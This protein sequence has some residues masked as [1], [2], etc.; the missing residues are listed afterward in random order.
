MKST[1]AY[2]EPGVIFI[3]RVNADHNINYLET[4]CTTNPCGEKPMGPYASCL[5]GSINLAMLINNPFTSSACIDEEGLCRLVST[6]IRMMDNVIDV[7]NF[8]LE[9]QKQKALEDRQLGLGITGL[10]DAL[11]MIGITY[12]TEEAASQAEE[13]MRII[14][15]AA[16]RTSIQLAQEKGA[17]P[18]FDVDGF[19]AHG[20]HASR[21]PEDIQN[22]IREHGIRNALLTSIAPTGTISLYAGN[23]SSGIEP[24]FAT[25]YNRRVLT[26]DGEETWQVVEDY[27]VAAYR[28]WY[29]NN[30]R[31]LWQPELDTGKDLPDYFVTAQT[32]TPEAHVRMQAAV[33]KHVDS[34]I[35]KTVNLPE[36]I[37]FEDFKAVY[38]KAYDSGCKGCT[39]YRPNDVTGSV[40]SVEE[41]KTEEPVDSLETLN[42]NNIM[43]R[44]EALEGA[45]Y[46]LKWPGSDHALYITISDII[47]EGVQRPFEI[48][49][50]SKNMEHFQWTVA[51]TRMIS[52]V[53]RR[54]GDVSFVVEELKSV[55]D[56]Q[57]GAWV[58]GKYLPSILAAIGGVIELHMQT[59]GYA[60]VKGSLVPISK[61]EEP[62]ETEVIH[63]AVKLCSKCHSSNFIKEGGCEICKDCG[64]SACG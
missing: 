64:H 45:T 20:T 51:L 23:I 18:T 26:K 32:L 54:G 44:P 4:I 19:L 10:A 33:Q 37:S 53:F 1:Y 63:K 56:P 52:A 21:L 25:S 50:N 31:E 49:I 57:G 38:M 28:D 7:G 27:A 40:L 30:V 47:E 24:I 43:E 39:T 8:P 16:Y 12:G 41:A 36:D 34:S 29:D 61:K 59:I 46:K 35:S 58:K 48:F 2:A 42:T 13:W 6:A 14:S 9:A 62:V 15:H 22:G 11:T 5:L 55:F 3:D 60:A 17:F